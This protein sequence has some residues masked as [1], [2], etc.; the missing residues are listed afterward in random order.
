MQPEWEISAAAAGHLFATPTTPSLM[1]EPGPFSPPAHPMTC[2]GCGY[3]LYGCTSPLCPECGLALSASI[4]ERRL[5]A[6]SGRHLNLL[7]V[8]ACTLLIIQC[9]TVLYTAALVALSLAALPRA[10]LSTLLYAGDLMLGLVIAAGVVGLA[11]LPAS[12][13]FLRTGYARHLLLL[14]AAALTV[15]LL[16]AALRNAWEV[17]RIAAF[18]SMQWLVQLGV[19]AMWLAVFYY[20][21][22]TPIAL[23]HE[24]GRGL[25]GAHRLGILLLY[26]SFAL[27]FWRLLDDWFDFREGIPSTLPYGILYTMADLLFNLLLLSLALRLLAALR[28]EGRRRRVAW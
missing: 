8:M 17:D 16:A 27:L 7:A 2:V 10:V 24:E 23:A 20:Y 15:Y 6:L 5:A 19:G 3:L 1:H 11:T 4:H 9:H 14:S 25:R 22:I 12:L 21:L 26:S 13:R 28:R 18:S